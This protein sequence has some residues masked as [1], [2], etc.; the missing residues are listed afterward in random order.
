MKKAEELGYE[1]WGIDFDR[2]SVEVCQKKRALKNTFAMSLEEFADYCKKEGLKFDVIT[3]FEVLEHQ[4]KPKE[5]LSIVRSML[6]PNGW[7]AGSVPNRN[8]W[9][10]G[11][12]IRKIPHIDFPPHH[13]LRFSIISLKNSLE[14]SNFSI[15]NIIPVYPT[16]KTTESYLQ[17]Y[18]AKDITKRLRK[19]LTG[20]DYGGEGSI[21][22]KS[23][24]TYKKYIFKSLKLLK[25]I[26]F[27]PITLPIKFTTQGKWIYFQ[28]KLIV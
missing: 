21:Y 3:F 17:V 20:H 26:A 14:L 6:K 23:L 25:H 4:D 27:L 1:V 24:P 5:F 12:L 8:S 15:D 7:I 2:K 28:C 11:K 22:F 13:F 10:M 16:L 18:L 19:V 9:F